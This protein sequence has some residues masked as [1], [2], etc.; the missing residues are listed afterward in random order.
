[1]ENALE[2]ILEALFFLFSVKGDLEVVEHLPYSVELAVHDVAD[3]HDDWLH[4]KLNEAAG[5]LTTSAVGGI[6]SKLLLCG[7]EVVV[8]PKFLHELR[9]VKLELLS[10]DSCESSK[11]EG[12][13][14]ES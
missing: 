3:E 11:S 5:K 9:Y 7:V 12:P 13:T 1:L 8:T 14:E 10:V 2:E 4:D 6:S